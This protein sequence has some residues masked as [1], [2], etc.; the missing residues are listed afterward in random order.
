MKINSLKFKNLNSLK[1]DFEIN[2]AE[3]PFSECGIFAITGATGS[4]KTTILDAICLALYHKT[5]RL[6]KDVEEIMS[7]HT[8]ECNAEVEFE[9]GET[10]YRSGFFLRYAKKGKGKLQPAKVELYNVTSNKII[11][12]F[13]SKVVPQ[14]T[15]ITGLNFNQFTRSMMLAQGSFA[16]FL[17]SKEHDR[18]ELL[19]K[20]TGTEI[21]SEISRKVYEKTKKKKTDLD[22]L[23]ADAERINLKTKE[24]L[25]EIKN[26]HKELVKEEKQYEEQLSEIQNSLN[27]YKE[28][29]DLKT[30]LQANEK[31]FDNWNQKFE[32]A[33][34]DLETLEKALELQPLETDYQLLKNIRKEIEIL[35]SKIEPLLVNL[36]TIISGAKKKEEELIANDNKLQSISLEFTELKPKIIKT[37]QLLETITEKNRNLKD[38]QNDFKSKTKEIFTIENTITTFL[39]KQSELTKTKV[40]AEK[41][42]LENKKDETLCKTIGKVEE[43]LKNLKSNSDKINSF[44]IKIKNVK[45]AIQKNIKSQK[46]YLTDIEKSE[47]ELESKNSKIKEI[48]KNKSEILIDQTIEELETNL[49]DYRENLKK[50]RL[51]LELSNKNLSLQTDIKKNEKNIDELKKQLS[52]EKPKLSNTENLIENL[53]KQQ[54]LLEENINLELKVKSLDDLRKELQRGKECPLCGSKDHPWGIQIPEFSDKQNQLDKVKESIN[55]QRILKNKINSEIIKI[56]AELNSLNKDK[57]RIDLELSNILKSWD[58]KTMNQE[59]G[60][61]EFIKEKIKIG[62]KIFSINDEKIKRCRK[63]ERELAKL[64]EFIIKL[65]KEKSAAEIQFTKAH[66]ALENNEAKC[67]EDQQNLLLMIDLRIETIKEIDE[68]LEP[69]QLSYSAENTVLLGNIKKRIKL[70]EDSEKQLKEVNEKSGSIK[71]V[72]IAEESKI[73][74]IKKEK[75]IL[76]GKIDL[77]IKEIENLKIEKDELIV[78]K[79]PLKL[80]SD[81]E[82]KISALTKQSGKLKNELTK[83]EKMVI[84]NQTQLTEKQDELKSKMENENFQKT[85]FERKTKAFEIESLAEFENLRISSEEKK[86]IE[87]LKSSLNENKIRLISQKTEKTELLNSKIENPVTIKSWEE[88]IEDK[89][90]ISEKKTNNLKKQ[91]EIQNELN[92]Q[93]ELSEQHQEKLVEISNHQREYSAWN[94]LNILIGSHSGAMF[95]N[96]AQGLTLQKL[97]DLANKHLRKLDDRYILIREKTSDLGINVLDTFQADEIRP[98]QNLSGG[99]SFIVSLSLALGLSDMNSGKTI[100]SSL[101]LDEGF[102]TLDSDNLE[103]ALSVLENLHSTG[104]TI[105]IISH[106]KALQERIPTQINVVKKGGGVSEIEIK[107]LL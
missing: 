12:T 57:N 70:F 79:E 39:K 17:K 64:K 28:I 40:K 68:T 23:K 69:Y 25:N 47:N 46:K 44:E 81:F 101:F 18:A 26:T 52:E 63:F 99:E 55:K 6:E 80:Q 90:E 13:K 86:R 36:P 15:E 105:G 19:E 4:G 92:I 43:L 5:P 8:Y 30:A 96:F 75:K 66:S 22:S 54:L 9:A 33:Q 74:L 97:I 60:N 58:E 14:I 87:S 94:K 50:Y 95:R 27:Y 49:D 53:L 62:E 73:N 59:I 91:G 37:I 32:E 71:E 16:A 104:K 93:K 77:I 20:M 41:Y 7:R 2:F 76:T 29:D 65:E 88:T 100:I 31:L 103:I 11:E 84:L 3:K 85:D 1:G 107:E 45:K 72:L 51:L 61:I 89:K 82:N 56:E 24:E 102:G 67:I 38:S 83:L 21:Y 35:H 78:E 42:L 34:K 10:I 106:V 48:S 98:I